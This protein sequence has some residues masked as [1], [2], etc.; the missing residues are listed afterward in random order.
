MAKKILRFEVI[1]EYDF[2]LL[3]VICSYKDYRLCFEL[4]QQLKLKLKREKDLEVLNRQKN[5]STFSNFYFSSPDNEQF[6][7][8][9]NKGGTRAFI[10]EMK[11]IDYFI[12]IKNLTSKKSV[13]ELIARIKKIEIISG[14]YEMDPNEL[15]SAE[16]FLMCE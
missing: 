7:V 9:N 6:R 4:N 8:I 11:T 12:M 1:N 14:V 13:D 10:P 15:K 5:K 16:N 2:L 3:A